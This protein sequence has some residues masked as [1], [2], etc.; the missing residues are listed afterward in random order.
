MKPRQTL[1]LLLVTSS[2]LLLSGC[3]TLSSSKQTPSASLAHLLQTKAHGSIPL[4]PPWI[5]EAKNTVRSGWFAHHPEPAKSEAWRQKLR[6]DAFRSSD[7]QPLFRLL[8]VGPQC[9]SSPDGGTTGGQYTYRSSLP[10]EAQLL[11]S[12]T[13]S[14]LSRSLGPSQNPTD[15]WG[16]ATEWHSTVGWCFFTMPDAQTIQTVDIF[17]FVERP[18]HASQ[19]KIVSMSVWRG[20]AHPAGK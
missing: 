16:T 15:V 17:C 8:H 2:A 5:G 10:S 14:K 11:A 9:L 13:V 20:T 6:F 18:I 7:D 1:A 12:K 19:W 4:Q 3:Q